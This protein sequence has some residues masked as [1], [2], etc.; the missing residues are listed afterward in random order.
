MSVTQLS[1]AAFR[2]TISD[3]GCAFKFEVR[4][5]FDHS[6]LFFWFE[7]RENH[8][9]LF[10]GE[11]HFQR[12]CQECKI[13]P[14]HTKKNAQPRRKKSISQICLFPQ[15]EKNLKNPQ[16]SITEKQQC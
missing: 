2:L 1:N 11:M 13:R 12:C 15:T 8:L 7:H 10:I 4:R 3:P 5:N 14:S 16:M 9:E 6:V